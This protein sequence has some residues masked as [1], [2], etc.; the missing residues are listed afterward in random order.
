MKAIDYLYSRMRFGK[1][2]ATVDYGLIP[3]REVI[4]E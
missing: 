4:A 2:I 3:I 1:K